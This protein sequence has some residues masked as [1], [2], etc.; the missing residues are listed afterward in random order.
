MHD[1]NDIFDYLANGGK[2]SVPDNAPPRYRA[3]LLRIMASF[4]DSELAGAAGFADLI[5]AGPGIRERI[6]ASRIVLE[7]LNHAERVLAIMGEFGANINRYLNVHPWS[8]RVGREDD[9]G[10]RTFCGRHASQCF[11]LSIAGLDGWGCYE[12][13]NGTRDGNPTK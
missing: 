11:S 12:C 2:L 13:V 7:K 1:E 9:L 5:N 4:V 3:E 6:T 8:A 10:F